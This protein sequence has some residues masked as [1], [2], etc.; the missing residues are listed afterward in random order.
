MAADVTGVPGADVLGR[1]GPVRSAARIVLV[2][3]VAVAAALAL[4]DPAHAIS[5]KQADR[6]AMKALK[7]KSKKDVILFRET[8]R[9]RPDD[10]ITF[11]TR[12]RVPASKKGFPRL[13][14]RSWLYWQDLAP[15][16][17]FEHRSVMLVIDD[18]TGRVLR[19]KKLLYYPIVNG[20]RPAYL[21]SAKAYSRKRY[22]AFERMTVRIPVDGPDANAVQLL[23]H[24]AAPIWES[25]GPPRSPSGPA[26]DSKGAFKD[27][28]MYL[29]GELDDPL[30]KRDFKAMARFG[31]EHGLRPF[32]ANDLGRSPSRFRPSPAFASEGTPASLKEDVKHLVD[33]KGCRDILIFAAGHGS[34]KDQTPEAQV[35]MTGSASRTANGGRAQVKPHLTPETIKKVVKAFPTTTFKLKIMSC[36]SGRFRSELET[37]SGELP[38]NVLVVETSAGADQLSYRDL[39]ID[40]RKAATIGAE[41]M[42]KTDPALRQRLDDPATREAAIDEVEAK[43]RS[44]AQATVPNT[45]GLFEFTHANIVGMTRYLSTRPA[46]QELVA[47]SEVAT[48]LVQGLKLG[49]DAN[50]SALVG[51]ETPAVRVNKSPISVGMVPPK[52]S[53]DCQVSV[54]AD[55]TRTNLEVMIACKGPKGGARL[56]TTSTGVEIVQAT[57]QGGGTSACLS[58]SA[59][60]W[61]CFLEDLAVASISMSTDRPVAPGA[62][63]IVDVFSAKYPIDEYQVEVG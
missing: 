27:D 19:R 8:S 31:K 10:T 17:G 21:R 36:Y 57:L 45:D 60:R 20:K 30:F 16:A 33:Q 12:N 40:W 43:A 39:L 35:S 46:N 13:G 49:S 15:Y 59:Q 28:C 3:A 11:A 34:S 18:R 24:R 4:G 26:F 63:L 55:Q 6:I 7:T 25:V 44:E 54:A 61:T 47:G 14:K 2:G 29:V 1:R 37:G 53:G 58:L 52:N 9:L 50:Q 51:N 56:D 38:P 32:Y 23:P 62:H 42:A 48:M 41:A 22:R 5:R